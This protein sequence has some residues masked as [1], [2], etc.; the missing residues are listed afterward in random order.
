LKTPLSIGAYLNKIDATKGVAK[1]I[2]FPLTLNAYRTQQML[3]HIE[4]EEVT[5]Q[6]PAWM[7]SN[8]FYP[9]GTV[10]AENPSKVNCFDFGDSGGGL[11]LERKKGGYSWEGALSSYRG[12]SNDVID[13]ISNQTIGAV[14]NSNAEN[15][16]VFTEGS[17]F[18]PWIAASYGMKLAKGYPTGCTGKR[19]D[20]KDIDKED[21]MAFNGKK[22]KFDTG[23]GYEI[24]PNGEFRFGL[25]TTGPK[26]NQCMLGA[27]GFYDPQIYYLCLTDDPTQLQVTNGTYNEVISTCANNCPGVRLNDI[28]AGGLATITAGAIVPTFTL[29]SSL[30]GIGAVGLGVGGML[31]AGQNCQGPA[32]CRSPEGSCCLLVATI[33]GLRCPSR[34]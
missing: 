13:V 6:D 9:K 21:C 14:L 7:N 20:K 17:C 3:R 32:Y 4:V 31:L 16:G 15:P 27:Q 1:D 5:C 24:S 28:V 12:C 2:I 34:C 29:F 23:Y 11:F 22:C 30:L 33:G 8:S 26:F 19:G 18:L 10:C 25:N